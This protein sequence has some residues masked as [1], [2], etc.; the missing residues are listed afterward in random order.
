MRVLMLFRGEPWLLQEPNQRFVRVLP[1]L[2][3][4]Q[5]Y[6]DDYSHPLPIA[7]ALLLF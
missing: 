1:C 5:L 4:N 7:I 2:S 3:A 6:D